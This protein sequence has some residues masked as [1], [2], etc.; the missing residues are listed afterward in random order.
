MVSI[1]RTAAQLIS[2]TLQKE[3]KGEKD[4]FYD[5]KQIQKDRLIGY[6]KETKTIVKIDKPSN[7]PR[8]RTLGY[9]AKRGIIVVRVR[10][11]KGSGNQTRPNKGRKHKRMG[12]KKLTRAINTRAMSEQKAS[13][14]YP[15]LE[16][17]NSY[18]IAEDGKSKYY[19]IILISPT[20]PEIKSDKQLKWVAEKGHKGRAERG[21]TSA[22]KKHRGLR[23]KGKGVEKVRPSLRA[24][25]RMGT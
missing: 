1:M 11:R 3:R 9:K 14:R 5:Y 25:N 10:V 22:G 21:K 24:H 2:K 17:L 13:K 23:Y 15:N 8:A 6:R 7:I 16:V 20:A 4:E 19:E 18:W 12:V